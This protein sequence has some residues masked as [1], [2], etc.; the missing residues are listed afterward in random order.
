[1]TLPPGKSRFIRRHYLAP[2][3][4][5]LVEMHPSR[6]FYFPGPVTAAVLVLF[7]DYWV[8]ARIYPTLPQVPTLSRWL[9]LLPNPTFGPGLTPLTVIAIVLTVAVGV[10]ASQRWY[11]WAEQ[12]YA[13]TNERLI[14]QKGIVRHIIEEIPLQQVR[15]MNVYQQ[16]FWAR[17]FRVGTI[18]VQ[19]LSELNIPSDTSDEL[20]EQEALAKSGDVP[21]RTYEALKFVLDPKEHLARLS[22]IEW[23]VGVPNPFR[24][25]RLT[26]SA[27][28]GFYHGGPATGPSGA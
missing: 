14:Q 23:W 4:Q 13:V 20:E 12:T 26:Q 6:W 5:V 24:I 11:M 25:E 22:G 17:V 16:S 8:A 18:R 1:M 10:F 7:F 19:S 9:T 27:T 15:D 28:R 3:E 2:E 21:Y